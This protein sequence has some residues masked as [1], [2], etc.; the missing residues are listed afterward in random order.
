MAR[1]P[2]PLENEAGA[3]EL[4]PSRGATGRIATGIAAI[5]LFAKAFLLAH[6]TR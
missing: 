3:R 5:A 1:E 6:V 4:A 2:Q